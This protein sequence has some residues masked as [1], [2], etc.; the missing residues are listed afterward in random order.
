MVS[1]EET[2]VSV[3]MKFEL[4]GQRMQRA[5]NSTSERTLTGKYIYI[6]KKKSRMMKNEPWIFKGRNMFMMIG[7]CQSQ[8]LLSCMLWLP[9]FGIFS[10]FSYHD[11]CTQILRRTDK[12]GLFVCLCGGVSACVRVW[13]YREHVA[14]PLQWKVA[15]AACLLSPR[16]ACLSA[17][18]G[19]EAADLHTAARQHKDA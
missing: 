3:R 11:S 9:I 12:W 5:G 18:G 1:N 10:V 14:G 4:W 8:Y 15:P 17:C 2:L 6:K 19:P 16:S 7:F 13:W